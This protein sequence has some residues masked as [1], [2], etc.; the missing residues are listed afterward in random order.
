MAR[1]PGCHTV[2]GHTVD[3]AAVFAALPTAYLVLTPDLVIVDANDAY[4]R[5][6]G[7][8]RGDIV[9]RP[10]FDAFPPTPDALDE[11][12]VP[13]V[14]RSFE[15]ARD[16]GRTD[17]MPIQRYDLL[18]PATGR[19]TERFW[20]LISVPVLD[21]Q[22]RTALVLQRTEDIS[23]YLRER[24]RSRSQLE[25]SAVW[26]QRVTEAEADLYARA[27][28]LQAAR[29]AEARASR[30]LAAL[31]DVALQLAQTQTVRGAHERRGRPRAVALGAG[32]GALAVR[33]DGRGLSVA[34]S[35]GSATGPP[36][37]SD[38][39]AAGRAAA[40]VGRR[41][42]PAS[43]CCCRA[44]A[45]LA[46]ADEMRAVVEET[47]CVSWV[48]LPLVLKDEPLGSLT[49]GWPATT[50]SSRPSSTCWT[51]SP[52]SAPTRCCASGRRQVERALSAAAHGM[53][54]ALQRS[55]LTEPPQLR[56]PAGRG[57]LPARR[58]RGPGR[59]RLVRRLPHARRAPPAWWS[60]TS[61]GTTGTRPPRW[62]SCATSLRGLALRLAQPPAGLLSRARPR[63][64]RPRRRL[65]GHRRL[66]SAR[67]RA[68]RRRHRCAGP[69]PGIRRRCCCV[70]DG[71]YGSWQ[72]SRTCCSGCDPAPPRADHERRRCRRAT[73][74][75]STPTAWSSAGTADL[76]DG[77]ALAR[78]RRADPRGRRRPLDELCDALSTT[79][80][81][82]RR[83]TSPCW[84]C[85]WRASRR[86]R[87]RGSRGR[88]G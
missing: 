27:Q 51:R 33:E 18:D 80:G 13:H 64:A 55:L 61:P 3:H 76:D 39:A 23:D 14:Q 17:T 29:E 73:R 67:R 25:Q 81:T 77:P 63:D 42:G 85:A 83:T 68:G 11:T 7:R 74:C 31:A 46:F 2:D 54:Q 38:S 36:A 20:S 5:L 34:I 52:C 82:P 47:G 78:G 65:A 49:V 40:R 12:G 86:G 45:S 1:P 43:A 16:T 15:R 72:P 75:C 62:A 8:T 66:A 37:T 26:R 41:P 70:P 24:D 88:S 19:Y 9:G 60:A 59:R 44:G 10:V 48:S 50:P 6:V 79:C 4:L 84:R 87:G 28:E 56:R 22:G 69:T 58:A 71:G 21:E 57:P 35:G 30:R 32:G 53:A